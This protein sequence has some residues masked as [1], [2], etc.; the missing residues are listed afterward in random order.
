MLVDSFN[1]FY[2]P[3]VHKSYLYANDRGLN[4]GIPPNHLALCRLFMNLDG[5][6]IRY[7]IKYVASSCGNLYR[8][9]FDV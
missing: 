5:H 3:S 9:N 4:F 1:W 6:K 8:H 2:R 7:G